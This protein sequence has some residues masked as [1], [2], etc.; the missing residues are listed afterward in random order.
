MIT[1]A[2]YVIWKQPELRWLVE[3]YLRAGSQIE[4]MPFES[5]KKI[6]EERPKPGRAGLLWFPG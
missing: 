2:E 4:D 6:M 3:K 1:V 5:W